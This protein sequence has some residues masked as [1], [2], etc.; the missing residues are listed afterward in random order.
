VEAKVSIS[1]KSIDQD[2][3]EKNMNK[4]LLSK[5]TAGVLITGMACSQAFAQHDQHAQHGQGA[6]MQHGGMS[7]QSGPTM[8]GQD[9]FAAI[10]EIVQLLEADPATDWSK[11]NI[12]SLREHL[13][14]M[15]RVM[16][17]AQVQSE[18]LE[19]GVR[20]QVSGTDE[21][22][23]AVQRMV[24]AHAKQM[25]ANS[26]WAAETRETSNGVTLTITA[27][28]EA[29]VAK[30]RALGFAGFMVQGDH[31]L[32]HHLQM[33]TGNSGAHEHH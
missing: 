16:L 6:G 5:F 7:G 14:D 10:Q 25:S 20:Y 13:I 17:H 28:N 24:A 4:F 21:T 33:A 12:D 3:R 27:S 29:Q 31:H 2:T 23:G 8:V 9:A 15:N 26:D 22:V 11:V 30:I 18:N 1:P 32:P 19:N